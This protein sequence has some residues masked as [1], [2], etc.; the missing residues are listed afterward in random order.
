MRDLVISEIGNAP[1]L[2]MMARDARYKWWTEDEREFLFDM[3]DDSMEQK[4]LAAFPEHR[5]TLNRMREHILTFLR[6]TL[7]NFAEGYKPK[8]QR[9]READ[10]A[11]EK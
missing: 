1:P 11:K 4:N 7:V 6:S 10:A 8:V 3:E 9:L 2:R 5:E